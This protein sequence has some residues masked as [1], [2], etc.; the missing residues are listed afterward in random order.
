[1]R[2]VPMMR[3]SGQEQNKFIFWDWRLASFRLGPGEGG[4]LGKF[5]LD[6]QTVHQGPGYKLQCWG[7]AGTRQEGTVWGESRERLVINLWWISEDGRPHD[8]RDELVHSS[9]AGS[10]YCSSDCISPSGAFVTVLRLQRSCHSGV[11]DAST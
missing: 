6:A 5:C 10:R 3:L 9:S 7:W 4:G 8:L 2:K 11:D 1:M